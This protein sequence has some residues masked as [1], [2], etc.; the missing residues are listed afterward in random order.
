MQTSELTPAQREW[1]RAREAEDEF[2]RRFSAAEIAGMSMSEFA[3]LSG[4]TAGVTS[5][6]RAW[7]PTAPV[8]EHAPERL[9]EPVPESV[10][11]PRGVSVPEMSAAEYSAARPALGMG[12]AREYGVGILD[13]TAPGAWA[14]AAARKAGRSAMV[15]RNV[16]ES[17]RLKGRTVL[18][19]DEFRDTRTVA[20]RFSMPGNANSF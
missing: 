20:E 11:G 2:K 14:A 18:K 15:E 10:P 8:S 9:S 6:V 12:R 19:Q 13:G 16:T 17:P 5:A 3:A 4:R 1:Q 7:Q